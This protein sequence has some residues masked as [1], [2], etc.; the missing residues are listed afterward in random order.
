MILDD[1]VFVVVDVFGAA[2]TLNGVLDN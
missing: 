2:Y 1:F